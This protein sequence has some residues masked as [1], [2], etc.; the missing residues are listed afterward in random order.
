M[1]D[2]LTH[3][4]FRR[5]DLGRPVPESSHA[6]SVCLATWDQNVGYEE[7]D[8]HVVDKMRCGYPRFFLHPL[9]VRLFQQCEAQF[10]ASDECCFVFPTR[11][12]AER[13]VNFIT[14]RTGLSS[15]IHE[16]DSLGLFAV[17]L[18]TEARQA[19]MS[20]WQ[21]SGE[22]VSSRAAAI[23]LRGE[24]PRTTAS[25]QKKLIRERIAD[26]YGSDPDDVYLFPSGMAAIFAAYRALQQMR[27]QCKPVQFGFPYVDTLKILQRFPSESGV[28]EQGE[29]SETDPLHFF[30]NGSRPELQELE[31]RLEAEQIIGLFCEIPGNPLLQTPDLTR[32]ADLARSFQFPIVVDDT[33]GALINIDASAAADMLAASLTKF[34]SGRGDVMGG[35]LILNRDKP[36]Y[37]AL[38]AFFNEDFEDLFFGED[39]EVLERNSRD[40]RERVETINRNTEVLC[41][42]LRHHPAVDRV[43]Y[44]KYETPDSYRTWMR[45][46]GG[47]GGLFSLLLHDPAKTGPAFFDALRITKGPNLGTNFTLCCPYTI[48]AHYHELE[49]AESCGISP[50]LMRV[51]VGLEEPD[52]LVARFTEAL[53]GVLGLGVR[54]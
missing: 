49:F 16:A 24:S 4:L 20:Y 2:L 13:A 50:Y 31:G 22:I 35:S 12:V 18:P 42:A 47:F 32:L 54:D 21:H 52:W 9:V 33:L 45:P 40:F 37:G 39:A 44:P 46:G 23:A 48:L 15:R 34:F 53:D 36:F 26:V 25:T 11:R 3:P 28:D 41:E 29:S 7:A 6:V 51:S 1:D 19:A 17:C 10:A 38:K 30:P 27:P 5:D 8:P 43:F 14:G